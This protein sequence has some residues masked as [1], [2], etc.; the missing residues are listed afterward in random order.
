M[1]LVCPSCGATHSADGIEDLDARAALLIAAELPA[2]IGATAI[3]YLGLFRPRERALSWGRARKLLDELLPMIQ[4]GTI[5]RQGRDWPAPPAAWRAAMQ[6]MLD[7]R[8]NLELPMKSHGYLL[9]ILAGDANKQEARAEAVTEEQ[10]RSGS[11]AAVAGEP[12]P[13][14]QSARAMQV[15]NVVAMLTADATRMRVQFG[16]QY[17][18]EDAR[19]YLGTRW[20]ADVVEEGIATWKR[21]AT[22]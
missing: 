21:A 2:E 5:R 12:Q 1:R 6:T 3:R 8:D 17:T 22:A 7:G 18:E 20:P 4:S 11:R 14:L 15:R 16:Q 19:S 10:R 9:S 13:L